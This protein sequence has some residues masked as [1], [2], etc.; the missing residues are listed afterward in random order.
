MSDP[1]AEP[2]TNQLP[3]ADTNKTFLPLTISVLLSELPGNV[4]VPPAVPESE[5]VEAATF[6][7]TVSP[8]LTFAN[9]PVTV[10][11]A[12]LPL[13]VGVQGEVALPCE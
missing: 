1:V 5:Y 12:M 13:A 11:A 6:C 2:A 9:E 7:G 4:K 10:N 8:E 3:S